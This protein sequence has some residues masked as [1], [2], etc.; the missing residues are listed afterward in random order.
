MPSFTEWGQP[1]EEWVCGGKYR[2]HF[3]FLEGTQEL[4]GCCI[5][6]GLR[7]ELVT[8][9]V[10]LGGPSKT[11]PPAGWERMR[12]PREGALT[13][14]GPGVVPRRAAE[15]SQHVQRGDGVESSQGGREKTGRCCGGGFEGGGQLSHVLL[16]NWYRAQ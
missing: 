5:V 2:F 4:C 16:R 8:G 14:A 11:W 1:G 9:S 7:G 12:F 13:V 10:S 3:V 15:E 6:T